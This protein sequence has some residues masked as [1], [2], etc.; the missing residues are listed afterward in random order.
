MLKVAESVSKLSIVVYIGAL[1]L[2]KQLLIVSQN[3]T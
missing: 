3:H 1:P 2:E